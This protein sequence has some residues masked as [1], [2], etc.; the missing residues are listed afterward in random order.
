MVVLAV[1]LAGLVVALG[2]SLRNSP[3][4]GELDLASELAQQRVELILAQRRAAGFAAFAD[5]CVPGPGPAACAVPAGYAVA[6]SIAPGWT[7]AANYKVIRVD[8][9]G[10]TQTSVTTLVGNH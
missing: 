2:S 9:T 7:D 8:V 3:A 5:P 1:L 6:S 10:P 4:A